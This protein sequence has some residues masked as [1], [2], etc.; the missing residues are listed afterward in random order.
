M[1]SCIIVRFNKI[2]KFI[3]LI[4]ICIFEKLIVK[5]FLFEKVFCKVFGIKYLVEEEY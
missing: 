5:L 2:L 1:Y 3:K 4:L